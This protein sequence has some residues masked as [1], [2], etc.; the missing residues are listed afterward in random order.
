MAEADRAGTADLV[1]SMRV[2]AGWIPARGT[3]VV[4]ALAAGV[5]RSNVV[6]LAAALGT[7]PGPGEA[8]GGAAAAATA[9]RD[10]AEP[11]V[12]LG[13]LATAW[14]RL[15]TVDLDRRAARRAA[16][17]PVGRPR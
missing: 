7:G 1:W 13:A 16:P 8:T 3:A 12:E 17:F 11:E 10:A 5:E 6:A 14:P 15:R 2:L 9:A 4:R